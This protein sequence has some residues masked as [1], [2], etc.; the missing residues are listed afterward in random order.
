M[1]TSLSTPRTARAF[2]VCLPS[3]MTLWTC[4]ALAQ[5]S[6]SPASRPAAIPAIEQ[7]RPPEISASDS[8]DS[9]SL[10][11]TVIEGLTKIPEI[12]PSG[13]VIRIICASTV[14][15]HEAIFVIDGIVAG[16]KAD[17]TIDFAAAEQRV[18]DLHSDDIESVEVLKREAATTRYGPSAHNGVV[19]ITTK[20]KAAPRP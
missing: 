17:S 7:L 8:A 19:L 18:A 12:R 16:L 6:T 5:S 2:G 1:L 11:S 14:P 13:P 15:R 9:R 10:R 4:A 3:L 20:R